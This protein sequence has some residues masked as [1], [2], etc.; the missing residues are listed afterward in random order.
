M[1]R[2]SAYAPNLTPLVPKPWSPT[3]NSSPPAPTA[4]T[5]PANSL[6]RIRCFGRRMP[7][8][9]RL[10]TVI[11]GPLRRLASRVAQ[12]PRVTA[13]ARTLTRTSPS[14]GAGR[15]TSSSRKTSGGPYLSYTTAL[16]S[17]PRSVSKLF[18]GHRRRP[19][20]RPIEILHARPAQKGHRPH[21]LGAEHGDRHLDTALSSRPESVKIRST[22]EAGA[23]TECK[24]LHNVPAPADA[25]V[26]EHLDAGPDR[27]DDLGQYRERRGQAVELTA[28]VVRDHDAVDALVR[29]ADRVL[30]AHDPLHHDPTLP[31][32]PKRCDVFPPE[33]RIEL[34]VDVARERDRTAGRAA[35]R[36]DVGEFDTRT[37]KHLNQPARA[38]ECLEGIL[39]GEARRDRRAV[40]MVALALAED[41]HI[42]RDHEHLIAGGRRAFDERVR[43]CAIA[44][45]V[46]LE[47]ERSGRRGGDILDRDRGQRAQRKSDARTTGRARHEDL[48]SRGGHAT[49][50]C[51]REDERRG[52]TPA[53]H[54]DRLIDGADI[55]KD[56]RRERPR[57]EDLLVARER[58]LVL[59]GAVDVVEYGAGQP[60]AGFATEIVDVQEHRAHAPTLRRPI[61]PSSRL[62]IRRLV[63]AGV[64]AP[65]RSPSRRRRART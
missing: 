21:H 25:A 26:E 27:V 63:A 55:D 3:A 45:N 59:G 32:R 40:S 57:I 47:P 50:T 11:A 28:T 22:D 29:S 48:A 1:Q 58:H 44:P 49:E 23:G 10:M 17:R 35:V 56:P 39:Y 38:L 41:G 46:E 8:I 60:P 64:R 42:R 2:Y 24:R 18:R 51:R 54:G 12:S 62:R 31:D 43:E 36:C 13:V 34:V 5:S 30:G 15:S 6:P 19:E 20:G 52:V 7:E 61:R 37:A 65:A 14:F 16:M 9:E 4:S 33:R 53:Q